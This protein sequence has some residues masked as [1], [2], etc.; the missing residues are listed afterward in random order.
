LTLK[1]KELKN[2]IDVY[3]LA[4]QKG[5]IPI[6]NVV[7]QNISFSCIYKIWNLNYGV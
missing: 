1:V 3:T 7:I 2:R 4:L 6:P 5:C